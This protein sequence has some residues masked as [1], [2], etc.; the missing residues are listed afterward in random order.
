MR[1]CLGR[2]VPTRRTAQVGRNVQETIR[3]IKAF[4][5]AEKNGSRSRLCTACASA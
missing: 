2:I 3:I 5:H 4:Q 1:T